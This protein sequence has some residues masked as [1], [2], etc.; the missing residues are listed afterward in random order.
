[1]TSQKRRKRRLKIV[2][3]FILL[4]I[5][6]GG[7]FAYSVWHSLHKSVESMY[8]KIE[9]NSDK[10]NSDLELASKDAFSVLL[11]GVD[12]RDGDSG[13]SDSMIVLTI[14]PERKSV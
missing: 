11:L 12:E 10:R 6:A 1:M 4:F 5:L 14:N 7:A 8:T 3:I 13:R 2:G 9:R